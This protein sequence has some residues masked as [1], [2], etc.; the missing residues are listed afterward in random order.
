MDH[1]AEG[2]TLNEHHGN[3]LATVN[4]YHPTRGFV[5]SS[6]TLRWTNNQAIQDLRLE[7]NELG[8]V[9]WRQLIRYQTAIPGQAASAPE[10]R[11]ETFSFDSQNRLTQSAVTGQTAQNF[12]QSWPKNGV[13]L[14]LTTNPHSSALMSKPERLNK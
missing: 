14:S 3:G 9:K 7:V 8:N 10:V 2:K 11:T 1:D 5:E 13:H 6:R 4:R 12:T